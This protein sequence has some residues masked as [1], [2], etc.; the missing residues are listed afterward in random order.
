MRSAERQAAFCFQ[1]GPI[2]R[3]IVLQVKKSLQ[4]QLAAVA[5]AEPEAPPAPSPSPP[6]PPAPPAHHHHHQ[7]ADAAAARPR[8]LKRGNRPEGTGHEIML[9]VGCDRL[10]RGAGGRGAQRARESSQNASCS[11]CRRVLAA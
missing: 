2:L 7:Q 8:E 1:T 11:A 9:Q 5:V 6:P 3:P 4:Q 10:G